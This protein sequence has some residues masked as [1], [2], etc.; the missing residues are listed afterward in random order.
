MS[1]FCLFER[2]QRQSDFPPENCITLHSKHAAESSKDSGF[3]SY[4]LIKNPSKRPK[5]GPWRKFKSY[6]LRMVNMSGKIYACQPEL[7]LWLPHFDWMLLTKFLNNNC[8]KADLVGDNCL[9]CCGSRTQSM[10]S[11]QHEAIYV[12]KCPFQQSTAE[13]FSV[14]NLT[15][16]VHC[17]VISFTGLKRWMKLQSEQAEL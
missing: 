5:A 1:S 13:S 9:N 2:L 7:S 16:V 11:C 17:F 12:L 6:S 15:N 4:L 10:T 3:V 8:F 14:D